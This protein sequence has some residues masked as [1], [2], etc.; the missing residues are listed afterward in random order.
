LK[1]FLLVRQ[2]PEMTILPLQLCIK[3]LEL[4]DMLTN[5]S[6]GVTQGTLDLAVTI[7]DLIALGDDFLDSA[8]QVLQLFL[9]G[10]AFRI[11]QLCKQ[12]R[13]GEAAKKNR[14]QNGS[15]IRC[16][17]H[18]KDSNRFANDINPSGEGCLS[19]H[20]VPDHFQ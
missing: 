10:S 19:R 1:L 3:L 16:S 9:L 7:T 13:Q 15:E 14:Y 8:A 20:S 12:R 18:G 6:L 11:A 5:L 4:I 2:L 17:Q